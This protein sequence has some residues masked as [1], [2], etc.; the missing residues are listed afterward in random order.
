MTGLTRHTSDLP[1]ERLCELVRHPHRRHVLAELHER[2]GSISIERLAKRVAARETETSADEVSERQQEAI[3]LELHHNHLPRLE[4]LG[5]IEYDQ[6]TD[7]HPVRLVGD[8]EQL[9]P[10]LRAAGSDFREYRID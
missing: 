1:P 8:I 2:S 7:G 4:S 5:L 3:L 6:S 9:K 10:A